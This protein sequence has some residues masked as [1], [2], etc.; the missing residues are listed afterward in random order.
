MLD[1]I[2]I[3]EDDN[4]Y[5]KE[6]CS[7]FEDEYDMLEASTGEAALELFK[8]PNN[9]SLVMLDVRLPGLNGV[10]VLDKIKKIDPSVKV[11]ML[12]G[13]GAKD[14]AIECLKGHADDFIEKN[15]K[16]DEI[17]QTIEKHLNFRKGTN[18]LKE[19]DINGKLSIIK[20]FIERNWFRKVDLNT[21]ARMVKMSPKYL[22]RVFKENLGIS[23]NDYRLSDK[24]R[25]SRQMLKTSG[26]NVELIAEKLGY[27]NTE[28]YIR[29][30]KKIMKT[31]P[32]AFRR[33]FLKKTSRRK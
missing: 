16:V 10:Q 14:V 21:A 9:I 12:T 13:Y 32:S 24:V 31:T 2:L 11:L 6:L 25:R 28:S 5:R 3:V 26:L 30:F 22:S 27:L 19:L 7:C 29:A 23:F 15:Q 17:K 18:N 33:K 1:Q 20:N 8:K 4:F